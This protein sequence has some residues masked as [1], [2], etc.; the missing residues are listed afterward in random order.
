MTF[1]RILHIHTDIYAECHRS[2]V[3]LA[4]SSILNLHVLTFSSI[5][6][7][8]SQASHHLSL[9]H[10]RAIGAIGNYVWRK[11]SPGSHDM[12]MFALA[13]RLLPLYCARSNLMALIA[14]RLVY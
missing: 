14:S 8:I 9:S 2:R 5:T 11:R 4:S 12:Y 3:R 1:S 6:P 13:V 7:N 10:Y